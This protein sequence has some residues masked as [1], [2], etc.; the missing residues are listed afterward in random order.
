MISTLCIICARNNETEFNVEIPEKEISIY[1]SFNLTLTC[2]TSANQTSCKWTMT[3]IPRNDT[4][5]EF[6]TL[7]NHLNDMEINPCNEFDTTRYEISNSNWYESDICATEFSSA[8]LS[9]AGEWN[10]ELRECLDWSIDGCKDQI[11]G[12]N[13]VKGDLTVGVKYGYFL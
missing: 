5:C 3:S 7:I 8:Q 9:L 4:V 12:G 11:D 1:Q 6:R 2:D 10:C 13:I